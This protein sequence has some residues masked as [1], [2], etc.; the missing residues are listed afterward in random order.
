MLAAVASSMTM[1]LTAIRTVSRINFLRLGSPDRPSPADS[2]TNEA[3]SSARLESKVSS[4]LCLV[5]QS[6]KT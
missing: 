1:L 6:H 5:V 3:Q 2:Q 4:E